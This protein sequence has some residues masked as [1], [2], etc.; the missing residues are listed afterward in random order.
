[1]TAQPTPQRLR[2][3]KAIG[4][5]A[6]GEWWLE[7]KG[8]ELTTHV[9]QELEGIQ[10]GGNGGGGVGRKKCLIPDCLGFAV[11]SDSHCVRHADDAARSAYFQWVCANRNLLS[12]HGVEVDADLIAAVFRPPIV[13]GN[14]VCISVS[15]SGARISGPIEFKDLIFDQFELTGA[16][17]GGQLHINRC[18]FK[19]GLLATHV[20]LQE[21][22]QPSFVK[23]RFLGGADFS[24]SLGNGFAF[25][26]CSMS[27]KFRADGIATGQLVFVDSRFRGNIEIRHAKVGAGIHFEN[28]EIKALLDTRGTHCH[29]FI[30]TG[31]DLFSANQIGPLLAEGLCDFSR[32]RFRAGL[33]IDVDCSDL[34]LSGAQFE[35]GGQVSSRRGSVYLDKVRAKGRLRVSGAINS[36]VRPAILSL[37]NAD[38]GSM[39]FAHVDLTWCVFYG[40]HGLSNAV[41][42]MPSVRFAQSPP[43]STVRRCIAD[44]FVW[45]QR[46]QEWP[47]WNLVGLY[48]DEVSWKGRL[49]VTTK[50][51]L[52]ALLP[53]QVAS[54]YRELRHSLE[55]KSNRSAANDFYYGEMEMRRLSEE[56]GRFERVLLNAYRLASGYGLRAW[57][58]LVILCVILAIA[59]LAMSIGGFTHDDAAFRRALVFSMKAAIPGLELR[60]E[61]ELTILGDWIEI[62]L[63]VV[64]P[65]LIALAILAVRARIR[66]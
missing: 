35:K 45:R 62:S 42:E 39:T 52:P 64:G 33:D 27:R 14:K 13:S 53:S 15:F 59:S 26:D 6:T 16:T 54:V 20:D 37:K 5:R 47:G 2:Y 21:G 32:T 3:H 31:N 43:R 22:A 65:V 17:I 63:H 49:I 10:S 8:D 1:M 4:S 9:T 12:L 7:Q 61:T 36:D 30:A 56:T 44:E 50:V 38:A 48:R 24:H 55:S 51:E 60:T 19:E 46:C 34:R 40:A 57:R 25:T 28:C 58:A 41:L 66:R 11:C 18:T 29:N 23:C